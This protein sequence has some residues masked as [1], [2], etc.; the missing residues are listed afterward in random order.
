[1]YILNYFN[2]KTGL[3][4]LKA[5]FLCLLL[6]SIKSSY[7]IEKRVSNFHMPYQK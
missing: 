1:M 7:I 2:K 6:S 5:P 3:L 4:D